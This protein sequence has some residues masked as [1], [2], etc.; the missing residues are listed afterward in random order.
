MNTARTA[1]GLALEIMLS[2]RTPALRDAALRS[3]AT[4]LAPAACPEC[5]GADLQDDD[6]A[7][8]SHDHTLLCVGCGHQW[9]PNND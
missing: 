8:S 5:G 2:R 1:D 7:P 6:T 3:L 4:Q 9:N